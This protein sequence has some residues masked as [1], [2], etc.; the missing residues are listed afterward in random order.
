MPGEKPFFLNATVT[1]VSLSHNI[2]YARVINGNVYNLKPDTPGLDFS[3][4]KKGQI[5]EIEITTKLVRVLSA[6]L[7]E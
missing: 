1:E 5:V 7:I 2:A 6:R 3:K 4:L